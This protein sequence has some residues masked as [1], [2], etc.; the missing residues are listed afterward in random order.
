MKDGR[1][2]Y[3]KSWHPNACLSPFWSSGACFT[4]VDAWHTRDV[5]LMSAGTTPDE[6]SAELEQIPLAQWERFS[7]RKQKA[8]IRAAWEQAA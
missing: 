8:L 4:M 1:C 5:E 3:P 7:N 6:L 2:I